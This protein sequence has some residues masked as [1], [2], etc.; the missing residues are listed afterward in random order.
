MYKIVI[1]FIIL[2]ILYYI[3]DYFDGWL[4]T[5]F[6]SMPKMI[7]LTVGILALMFPRDYEKVPDIIEN[8]YNRYNKLN[9]NN[10][11]KKTKRYVGESLKK[12]VAAGQGWKCKDCI[13]ILDASYEIDHIIPLYKG[14]NNDIKNLQALCRNCH[15]RKTLIDNI[16]K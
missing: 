13:Q 4:L 9:V 5:A 1:F 14:G 7:A 8:T 12:Y 10:R 11:K 15:G 2:F 6:T 16:M 3:N